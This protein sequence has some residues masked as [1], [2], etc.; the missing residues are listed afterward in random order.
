MVGAGLAC[1]DQERHDE[2]CSAR[3]RLPGGMTPEE[4]V[5]KVVEVQKKSF[6][7]FTLPLVH[8]P[9]GNASFCCTWPPCQ[10]G[11]FFSI[12]RSLC[13]YIIIII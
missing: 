13:I 2:R 3:Y 9:S 7:C 11:D 5:E 6:L 4:I 10:L 8:F 12:F 1:W